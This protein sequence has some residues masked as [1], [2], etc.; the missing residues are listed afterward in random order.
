M[1]SNLRTTLRLVLVGLAAA[2]SLSSAGLSA[3]AAP[4]GEQVRPASHNVD[5]G[6]L[7]LRPRARMSSCGDMFL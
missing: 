2:G 4:A 6:P 5:W 3:A 1:P 7:D